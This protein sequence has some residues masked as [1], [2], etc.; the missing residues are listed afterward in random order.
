MWD[1]DEYDICEVYAS[2]TNGGGVTAAWD[3]RTF[4][5]SNKHTGSRW[6]LLEGC[7]IRHNFEC[8][9]G[10]IYGPNDRVERYVVFEELKSMVVA[11]DKPM[12]FWETS[13]SYYTLGKEL[14]PLDAI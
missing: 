1:N 2:D 13:M 7:I 3:T 10:V 6:I 4:S 8:C 12:L 14:V 5:V 9:V 11:I